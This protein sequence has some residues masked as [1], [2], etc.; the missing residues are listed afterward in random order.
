MSHFTTVKTVI[1]DQE[2][3]C[4][5]LRQLH[6][7]FRQGENEVV[8]GYQRGIERAQVVV[9]TGC[10]YDI[11]F[12]RQ[13]DQAFAAVADWN[14]GIKREAAPRFQQDT[15]LAEVHQKCAHLAL[16]QQV[17]EVGYAVEQERVLGNGEIEMVVY[18]PE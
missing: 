12:Q 17:V 11:G 1:R 7:Q 8:R 18:V 15:F 9:E 3:L 6:H 2:V 5:A 16:R 10:A 14:W 4:E 13:A